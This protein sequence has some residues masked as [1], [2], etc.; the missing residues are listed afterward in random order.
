ML[1]PMKSAIQAMST[2]HRRRTL[3]RARDFIVGS[4]M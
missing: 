3:N 2:N 1:I 4:P